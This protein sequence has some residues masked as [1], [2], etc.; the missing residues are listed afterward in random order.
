MILPAEG[1]NWTSNLLR[2]ASGSASMMCSWMAY[3]NN[4][5]LMSGLTESHYQPRAGTGLCGGSD[6]APIGYTRPAPVTARQATL[7]L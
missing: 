4:D 1:E 2:V 3:D 5:P 7:G 6:S